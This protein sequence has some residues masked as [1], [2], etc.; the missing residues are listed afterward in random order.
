[1][2]YLTKSEI[3]NIGFKSFGVNLKISSLARFYNPQ[4]ISLSDNIRIDDFC[5]VSGKVTIGSNVQ[6]AVYSYVTGCNAGIIMED[7]T[8]L[9]YGVKIFTDSDD[10][11]GNSLT[12]PTI[13]DIYKPGKISEPILIKKHSIVGANSLIFPGVTLEEGTAIGANSM[14]I[15]STQPWT[16]YVGSPAKKLKYRSK[17]ILLLEKEYKKNF[18]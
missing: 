11:S 1:M 17:N 9:A 14:V 6:L 8:T 7:F 12:N 10:Y 15:K 3:E 18:I 2:S 16:I 5:I 4:K 13:P